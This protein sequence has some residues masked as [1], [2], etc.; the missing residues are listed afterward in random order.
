MRK[1]FLVFL[2]FFVFFSNAQVKFEKGYLITNDGEKKEV[3]IKNM[4]WTGTPK[5]ISYKTNEQSSQITVNPTDIKEFGIYGAG[6]YIT[7]NGPVESS[8]DDLS[9][10]SGQYDPIFKDETIF[11]KE[12]SAGNKNLYY[13]NLRN[14]VKFFYSDGN[15]E[16][17]PLIYKRY[18]PQGDQ[19]KVATNDTYISQLKEIFKDDSAATVLVPKTKYSISSLT[20]IFSLHNDK[21]ADPNIKKEFLAETKSKY[22]LSIRPGVIF[23]NPIEA[24]NPVGEGNFPSKTN[25]R[26]GVE[27]EWVLPFNKNKW[28]ILI[29]PT[30]SFYSNDKMS[31]KSR[32]QLYTISFDSYSFIN[33]PLSIRHHMYLNNKSKL[34]VNV[35]IDALNFQLGN[36]KNLETDYDGEVFSRAKLSPVLLFQGFSAGAGF[37]YNN[38][39]TIEARYNGRYSLIPVREPGG[40][41]IKYSSIILGYN[42]F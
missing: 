3:L 2:L 40:M 23:F 29:E 38:K 25:F 5:D 21:D 1:T 18:N 7:Y 4:D 15:S 30:Y 12:L 14:A 22:N 9:I 36:G 41:A 20:K 39:F 32:D 16:I 28:S 24:S 13:Y 26:I 19:S 8:Y 42:I 17:K 37:T 34:F 11:L 35:G 10:L 27:A 33:I 6:K 31:F